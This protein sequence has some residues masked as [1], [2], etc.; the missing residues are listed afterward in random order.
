ME[1]EIGL[2]G[3]KYC[4]TRHEEIIDQFFKLKMGAE[5]LKNIQQQNHVEWISY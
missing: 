4:E 2:S 5:K 1:D 3:G